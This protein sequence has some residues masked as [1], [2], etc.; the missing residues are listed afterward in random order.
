MNRHLQ[1]DCET[2]HV[3]PDEALPPVPG[4]EDFRVP[5]EDNTIFIGADDN[6]IVI[7]G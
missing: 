1:N 7:E 6:V 5:E 4:D 2:F 3:P